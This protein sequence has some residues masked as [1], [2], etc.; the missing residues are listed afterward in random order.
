MIEIRNIYK[1]FGKGAADALVLARN[2][3]SKQDILARTSCTVGLRNVSL[4]VAAGEIFVVMGL[5][6]SG[7]STL[8]RHINRL[9]EPTDGQVLVRGRDVLRLDRQG[10]VNFRRQTVSMVFQRFALF[11]HLTVQDNV[12]YGLKVQGVGKAERAERALRWLRNVGL[13]GFERQLPRQLSGGMQQRVGLA[14]ALCTDP[15]ILLMDEPFSALDPLIRNQMQKQLMALQQNFCKTIVFITHDLDEALLLG[16]HIAILKDGSLEQV[17]RPQDIVLSPASSYVREFVRDVNRARVLT[18]AS[19]M[20]PGHHHNSEASVTHDTVIQDLLH[21]CMTTDTVLNVVD[22][23]GNV[24]G[25]VNREA[26]LQ[27]LVGCE[28]ALANRQ[29]QRSDCIGL[30][31]ERTNRT[32]A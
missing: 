4:N 29:V 23:S 27:A 18:A 19:I 14:R 22:G 28:E 21:R 1:I 32:R 16:D 31:A 26:V 7:K 9:I 24:V 10:L 2:G 6:G 11:P 8:I 17:G 13:D 20:T 3:Q 30:S 25:E 5:S 15:D 12:A